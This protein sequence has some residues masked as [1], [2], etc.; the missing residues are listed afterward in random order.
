M[1]KR[2]IQPFY[3]F[4]QAFLQAGDRRIG[5]AF[6]GQKKIQ[7]IHA[8][9]KEPFLDQII[10]LY[11][12]ETGIILGIL[13][14]TASNTDF[15]KNNI[16]KNTGS[17][18]KTLVAPFIDKSH[19]LYTDSYNTNPELSAFLHSNDIG[20][21]GVTRE[22]QKHLPACFKTNKTNPGDQNIQN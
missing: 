18:I 6:Q 14:F 19:I 22:N 4:F 21:C 1:L 2:K 12:C 13:P 5:R 17:I 20:S 8:N 11:D 3:Y 16:H 10:R 9:Q 15:N 7:T